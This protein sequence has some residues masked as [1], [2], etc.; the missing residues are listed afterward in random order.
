MSSYGSV[1][2]CLALGVIVCLLAGCGTQEYQARM[3]KRVESRTEL[4]PASAGAL[5]A[6]LRKFCID[7]LVGQGGRDTKVLLGLAAKYLDAAQL[8]VYEDA[9]KEGFQALPCESPS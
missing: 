1:G 6:D 5:R 9:L 8:K 2:R 3:A 4:S 7:W